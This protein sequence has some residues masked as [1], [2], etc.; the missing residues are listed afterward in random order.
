VTTKSEF[1]DWKH[2]LVTQSIF[3]N[4]QSRV[5]EM[6][7]YLAASAGV[8]ARQDAIYVGYILA[9]KDMLNIEFEGD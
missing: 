2:N 8:D 9:V 4:L 6:K 7:E 5:D 3:A 1:I